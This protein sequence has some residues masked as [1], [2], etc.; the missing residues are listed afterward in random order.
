M[1]NVLGS[2]LAAS[3]HHSHRHTAPDR[4]ISRYME[5]TAS[6]QRTS[7]PAPAAPPHAPPAGATLF[8]S[9]FVA[10]ATALC[11]SSLGGAVHLGSG[12]GPQ[13]QLLLLLGEE[14]GALG[15]AGSLQ[16]SHS[17]GVLPADL[18]GKATVAGASAT[19]SRAGWVSDAAALLMP[20]LLLSVHAWA[21]SALLQLLCW[22]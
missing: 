13:S 14:L 7:S 8:P 18:R 6:R 11:C 10:C 21:G 22:R 12:L 5:L 4:C 20:S 17:L 19:G 16:I 9:S 3:R 15:L 2:L 1:L